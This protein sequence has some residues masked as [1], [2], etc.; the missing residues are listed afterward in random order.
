V[1]GYSTKDVAADAKDAARKWATF[2][3]TPDGGKAP[4]VT[5]G[6]LKSF[7]AGGAKGQEA[8]AT[9]TVHDT[10]PCSPPRGV[11]HAA[12]VSLKTGEVAV[13]VVIADQGVSDQ[14]ADADLEKIAQS[15]R[16]TA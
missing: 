11:V 4:T 5:A 16:P 14:A 12:A 8:T 10:D 1:S 2:G 3:Y 6:A 7:D 13:L 15:V 9:V